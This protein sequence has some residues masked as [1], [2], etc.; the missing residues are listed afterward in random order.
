MASTAT[1]PPS[2]AASPSSDE[3]TR[4]I[5]ARVAEAQ[6]RYE[7]WRTDPS[8]QAL[9]PLRKVQEL[10]TPP[11]LARLSQ[12]WRHPHGEA[13]NNGAE[14]AGRAFRH[15]QTP[16]FRLRTEVAIKGPL[17]VVINQAKE[18]AT[19]PPTPLVRLC[20]RGR[21]Q[22]SGLLDRRPAPPEARHIYIQTFSAGLDTF[23]CARLATGTPHSVLQTG[24]WVRKV[25]DPVCAATPAGAACRV[26]FC[27][28]LR[29][30]VRPVHRQLPS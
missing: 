16:H 7:R 8:Y 15:G 25:A 14:R 9:T 29:P 12:F 17:R 2:Y 24:Q 23:R 13:T 26:V 6:D 1:A 10:R 19:A 4:E 22:L 28:H 5:A 30:Q 21:P 27:L 3:E 11:R 20:P 18:R